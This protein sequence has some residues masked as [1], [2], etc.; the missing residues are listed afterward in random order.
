MISDI[1]E[2]QSAGTSTRKSA[3]NFG[4]FE[5][6]QSEDIASLKRLEAEGPSG[7]GG[8]GGVDV[9]RNS[10]YSGYSYR[11]DD[12]DDIMSQGEFEGLENLTS[13]T[14]ETR[15]GRGGGQ[16]TGESMIVVIIG[17]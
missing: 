4:G 5:T 11:S 7:G 13:Y 8:G 9:G 1:S 16:F 15:G 14:A 17:L 10:G 2:R 6:V 12:Y 3:S